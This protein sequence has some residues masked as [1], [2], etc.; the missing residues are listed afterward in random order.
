MNETIQPVQLFEDRFFRILWNEEAQIIGIEWKESTSA[1]TSEEFKT[2]LTLFAGYVEQK[3]APSILVDV[4]KF[5][6]KPDPDFQ[7]WR[8]KNISSRYN[9]AGVKKEVFLFPKN[10]PISPTMNQSSPGEVFLTRAF[11][12][13]HKALAWLA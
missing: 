9:A 12:D 5:R 7:P 11:D 13:L 8:V 1:M 3:K 10:A 4:N 6:H 2:E